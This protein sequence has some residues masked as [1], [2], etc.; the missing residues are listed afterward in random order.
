MAD[1][2][3]PWPDRDEQLELVAAI[4]PLIRFGTST[5]TYPGWA[6]SV[7]REFTEK[8]A[9]HDALAEYARWPLFRTVGIDS[10]FYRPPDARTLLRYA[11]ALPEDFRCVSKVWERVTAHTF[12]SPRA[13]QG[14][15]NADW[16]SPSL[17]E[18]EVL[19][20]MREHFAAHLGPMVF[21]LE[22]LP[23]RA[24]RPSDVAAR[25]DTFSDAL[26]REVPYAVE[27]RNPE[28]L[29]PEYFATLRLHNVAHV[30]N[31]WTRM[32]SIAEQLLLHDAFTANFAVVRALLRPGRRFAEAV[33]AF[34]PYDRI[35][36]PNPE[37]RASLVSFA[38]SIINL[39]IP[40]YVLV[41]NRA[42]GSSPHTI[43]AIARRIAGR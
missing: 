41:G 15:P 34:A 36:D 13:S 40:A 1:P 17:F 19:G 37:L 5:W 39:R 28:L 4:D 32:P 27:V 31:S 25:L 26:P 2:D 42:E 20:P 8:R 11:Q 24:M 33:D 3:D 18:N 6:G 10:F 35:R 43:G 22:A 16:L 12:K 14:G 9:A 21:E 29:T 7:Y 38:R 23:D 30:F